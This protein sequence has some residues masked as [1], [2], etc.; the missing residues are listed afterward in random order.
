MRSLSRRVFLVP[1]ALLFYIA[2]LGPTL[3]P[4][5]PGQRGLVSTTQA[6]AQGLPVSPSG[7]NTFPKSTLYVEGSG[8]RYTLRVEVA[9]TPERQAQGLMFRKSLGEEEGMVFLFSTPTAGGFWMKNTLIPLSIAFFDRKGVILRILD[10]A[11]CRMDPC[12]VYYP[13][14]LY[15]GALEV[16]AGWFARRKIREGARLSGPALSLWPK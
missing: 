4:R 10:M 5:P 16:N 13:G 2:P 9:D 14:V 11:P 3:P 12:P 6:L 1:L 8:A 15:Q 7:S